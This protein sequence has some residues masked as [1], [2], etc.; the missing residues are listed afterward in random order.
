MKR[1]IAPKQKHPA[2]GGHAAAERR[3]KARFDIEREM[4][5]KVFVSE[6]VIGGGV[7]YTLDMSSRGISFISD[8]Q[9]NEGDVV[10]L[11]ISWPVLLDDRCPLRLT[12]FGR[13]V[14]VQGVLVVCT[15]DRHEFRIQAPKSDSAPRF[16][17]RDDM[18]TRWAESLK[19]DTVRMAAA[20]A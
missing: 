10:E 4:R 1:S 13:V 11:S 19:R 3:T 16:T 12:V 9:F 15:V 20:S 7:G 14:R 6:R 8:R 5:Y 18:L 2:T 17:R